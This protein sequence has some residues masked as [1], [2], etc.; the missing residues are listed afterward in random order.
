MC[1]RRRAP[2]SW[3]EDPEWTPA[4]RS[5]GSSPTRPREHEVQLFTGQRGCGCG[6]CHPWEHHAVCLEESPASVD[7]MQPQLEEGL[8]RTWRWGSSSWVWKV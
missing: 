5:R 2:H 3:A 8:Q 6:P 7:L 4:S 1:F